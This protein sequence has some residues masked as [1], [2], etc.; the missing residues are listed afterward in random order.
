MQLSLEIPEMHNSAGWYT[1]I[2]RLLS[3]RGIQ[4]LAA[5]GG[6][7]FLVNENSQ[8][9]LCSQLTSKAAAALR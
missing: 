3:N 9:S 6:P 2:R 7:R 5:L 4:V 8:S 1:T